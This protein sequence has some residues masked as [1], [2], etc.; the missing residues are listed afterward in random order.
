MRTDLFGFSFVVIM[1]IITI[2]ISLH[3]MHAYITHINI[4][5]MYREHVHNNKHI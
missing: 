3:T 1:I 2:I 4:F 5:K